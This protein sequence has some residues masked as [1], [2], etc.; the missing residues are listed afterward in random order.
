MKENKEAII[1]FT[2]I[3]I[4]GKIKTRL[5]PCYTPLECAQL[6]SY[7][8][9]DIVAE[10]EKTEKDIYIFYAPDGNVKILKKVLGFEQAYSKQQGDNIG[11]RMQQ[12]MEEVFQNGYEKC[13]LI[14]SDV[15]GL[16][17]KHLEESFRML[18]EKDTV[19]GPTEDGG[20]YLIGSRKSI[21]EAFEESHYSQGEVAKA[22]K[23]KLEAAGY[24]VARAEKLLDIDTPKDL[25]D[26][27]RKKE[28]N[29]TGKYLRKKPKISVIIPIYNESAIIHNMQQELEKLEDCEILFVD[30]GSTDGTPS[31]IDEKYCVI[32]SEKGRANQ[33]NAGAMASGGEI[34][35]FLHC[36][37]KLP[38]NPVIEIRNV[39]KKVNWGCFGIDFQSYTLDLLVCKI[40]SNH[41]VKDRK[42]IF[43]DQGIF[44]KRKLFFEIGMYPKLPIMEDYQLSLTLKEKNEKIGMTKQRI[45]TSSRR[46]EGKF[47]NRIWVMWQMQR[48]RKMYRSGVSIEAI[49]KRYRDIR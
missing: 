32:S 2:R 12:S 14:G 40:V 31:L 39:M 37:S 9:R 34:L 5:M 4:P 10:C 22:T 23:D 46:F 19:L 29:F 33:M 21:P 7:F 25:L 36:D 16:K 26:Y 18:D 6:H 3:P 48:L 44:I 28:C 24:T 43:G 20:Y 47:L 35:F 11:S 15:P 27:G 8:L 49:S 41:R 13:I 30:G 1:I 17:A 45:S 42:I 38:E